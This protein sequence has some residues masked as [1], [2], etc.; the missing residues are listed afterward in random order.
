LPSKKK[1][2]TGTQAYE[3]GK[4]LEERVANWLKKQGYTCWQR[5]SARGK[6]TSRPYEVSAPS[7][8]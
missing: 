7:A 5:V 2:T 4:K 3:T 1:K 8:R 6:I